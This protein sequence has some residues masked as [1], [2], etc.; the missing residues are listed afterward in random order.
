MINDL[1]IAII[2]LDTS[3]A[4]AFTRML[5]NPADP[6]HLPGGRVIKAWAGGS[7]DFELS[8]SRVKQFTEDVQRHG[9]A[10]CETIEEAASGCDAILLESADGRVHLGQFKKLIPFGV[11][12]FIDKPL[13]CSYAEAETLARLA[14]E[15]HIPVMSS[16][17]LRFLQGLPE[18]TE[19]YRNQITNIELCGPLSFQETQAGY[20]WY[21]IHTIEMLF[22]ILGPDFQSLTVACS[23][24]MDD[25][26]TLWAG[27]VTARLKLFNG[28]VPFSGILTCNERHI[29]LPSSDTVN[30]PF[31]YSLLKEILNF[32]RSHSP[33][34][35]LTETLKL[36]AF[37]EK[38]NAL[39]LMQ[40]NK[41]PVQN[42]L[43]E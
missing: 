26:Q 16:S 38:A 7:A 32:F 31:Y 12:V 29:A 9:V 8:R 42:P 28:D 37:I 20:F 33:A 43:G 1:Q 11:P 19:K 17:S 4:P 34:V 10:I 35:P 15:H 23:E 41:Q 13:A 5:N 36:I 14:T 3:H 22:S 2:G 39:R 24:S 40:H 21:G 27:N 6:C 18:I 30:K 25:I